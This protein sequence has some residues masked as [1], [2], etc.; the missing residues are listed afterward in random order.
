MRLAYMQLEK[1]GRKRTM[2]KIEGAA[3]RRTTPYTYNTSERFHVIMLG[4]LCR[5]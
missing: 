2:P 1:K 4:C 5:R 3:V